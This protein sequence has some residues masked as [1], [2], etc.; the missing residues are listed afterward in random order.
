MHELGSSVLPG[1][2]ASVMAFINCLILANYTLED[3][4]RIRNEFT[5]K[6]ILSCQGNGHNSKNIKLETARNMKIGIFLIATLR[7]MWSFYPPI[8]PVIGAEYMCCKNVP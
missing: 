2:Q 1:Y 4:V 3:R 5:G 7:S 8:L 6:Y